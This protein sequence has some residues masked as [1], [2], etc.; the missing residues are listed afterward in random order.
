MAATSAV[1]GDKHTARWRRQGGCR[2]EQG[3]SAL[4]VHTFATG[5]PGL[6]VRVHG[7]AAATAAVEVRSTRSVL[8]RAGN[9]ADRRA[10]PST[11]E[12]EW[13][14]AEGDGVADSFTPKPASRTFS[15][16]T[17]ASD[18]SP[19]SRWPRSEPSAP[20]RARGRAAC[21]AVCR[22][23]PA[24]L[25]STCAYTS[26]HTGIAGAAQALASGCWL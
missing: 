13:R 20:G 1:S 3:A 7:V 2:K 10:D 4:R 8:C 11:G 26:Q 18:M 5:L 14:A 25:R 6:E 22:D 9:D 24:A 23:A 17:S 21:C 12:A 16:S 15:A 19:L